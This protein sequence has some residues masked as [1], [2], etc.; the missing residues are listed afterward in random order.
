[1]YDSNDEELIEIA[2]MALT[3]EEREQWK[4]GDLSLYM[5]NDG[6]IV[7]LENR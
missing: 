4:R 2:N 5:N 1:M 3:K 6:D 7:I